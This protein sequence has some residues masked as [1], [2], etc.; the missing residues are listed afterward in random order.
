MAV[1]LC[2]CCEHLSALISQSLQL[3]WTY[4]LYL[5]LTRTRYYRSDPGILGWWWELKSRTIK[6]K[7]FSKCTNSMQLTTIWYAYIFI[8]TQ[9]Y[10]KYL[11]YLYFFLKVNQTWKYNKDLK[12]QALETHY[13]F[14]AICL[15]KTGFSRNKCLFKLCESLFYNV[16]CLK[17]VVWVSSPMTSVNNFLENVS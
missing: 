7:Y 13:T 1:P 2:L 3:G 17:A 8:E 15:T 5:T 4:S 9:Y 16:P 12:R 14:A 11:T 10:I 6:Q